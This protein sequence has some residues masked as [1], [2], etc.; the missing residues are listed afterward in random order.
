[1][2]AVWSPVF[3]VALIYG[4]VYLVRY[5]QVNREYSKDRAE[6][7]ACDGAYRDKLAVWQA[8]KQV[9]N[10]WTYFKGPA[11]T[12][13]CYALPH[14]KSGFLGLPDYGLN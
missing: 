4:A 3:A 14:L 8:T 2:L 5:V 13:N 6:F 1:M 7:A 11:P 9:V 10:G 12:S